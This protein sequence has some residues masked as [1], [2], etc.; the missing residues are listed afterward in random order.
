MI[1][2]LLI[3]SGLV[4]LLLALVGFG[5]FALVRFRRWRRNREAPFS[6]YV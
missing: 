4:P 2:D 1:E 6:Y 3:L 5:R